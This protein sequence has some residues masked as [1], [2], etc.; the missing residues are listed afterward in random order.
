MSEAGLHQFITRA[1]DRGFIRESFHSEVERAYRNISDE[2]IRYGLSRRDW[3]V[4][5]APEPSKTGGFK[6][7]IRTVD[8]EQEELHLLVKPDTTTGTLKILTKY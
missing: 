8:V 7:L 5:G 4:K 2:D 3:T 1:L 6:Y